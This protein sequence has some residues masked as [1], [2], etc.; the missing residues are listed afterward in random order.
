M[1]VHE[2]LRDILMFPTEQYGQRMYPYHV[3]RV[4]LRPGLCLEAGLLQ[5][6]GRQSPVALLQGLLTQ[7]S[8]T[9]CS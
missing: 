6:A 1:T 2:G 4:Y 9:E 7:N 3:R 8:I 5:L